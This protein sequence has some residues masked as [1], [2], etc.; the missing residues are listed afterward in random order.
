MVTM[1]ITIHTDPLP[2]EKLLDIS[3]FIR[4]KFR[5]HCSQLSLPEGKNI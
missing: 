5:P 2:G 4:L 1:A 3:L